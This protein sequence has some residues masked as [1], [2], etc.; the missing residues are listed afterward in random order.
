MVE[1]GLGVVHDDEAQRRLGHAGSGERH[2]LGDGI[3]L[4]LPAAREEFE[5]RLPVVGII[6]VV[7]RAHIAY[8]VE[9]VVG[10]DDALAQRQLRQCGDEALPLRGNADRHRDRDSPLCAARS[11]S[12]V[13][14]DDPVP[15]GEGRKIARE[16]LARA[17]QTGALGACRQRRA[18]SASRRQKMNVSDDAGAAAKRERHDRTSF[19]GPAIPGPMA[20]DRR[21]CVAG[22]PRFCRFV[23]RRSAYGPP[24]LM[25]PTKSCASSTGH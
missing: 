2:E 24:P 13:A 14:G 16:Q 4:A 8:A 7:D 20:R 6:P 3:V 15:F 19:G 17:E 5:R 9:H 21:L 25:A 10:A 22:S 12:S 18:A 23:R 11:S 1:P